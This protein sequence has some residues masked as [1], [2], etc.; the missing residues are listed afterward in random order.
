[1]EPGQ[2]GTRDKTERGDL[3]PKRWGCLYLHKFNFFALDHS[4]E[5]PHSLLPYVEKLL[6]I[7]IKGLTINV[8]MRRAET[9]A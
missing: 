7:S 6:F 1:M 2:W 8:L 5:F 4:I 3:G 9:L